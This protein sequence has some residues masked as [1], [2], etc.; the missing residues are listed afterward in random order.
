MFVVA[1]PRWAASVYP[2]ATPKS[3]TKGVKSPK[4]ALELTCSV[5]PGATIGDEDLTPA[6]S[7][8]II[9]AI[10]IDVYGLPYENGISPP[11]CPAKVVQHRH[12]GYNH[13]GDAVL[14][15]NIKA[16]IDGPRKNRVSGIRC[17]RRPSVAPLRR[18]RVPVGRR[19][20]GMPRIAAINRDFHRRDDA[21]SAVTRSPTHLIVKAKQGF[22]VRRGDCRN[23]I[24][25]V[26]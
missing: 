14:V 10:V 22:D 18:S 19:L 4:P 13:A 16:V 1:K 8:I 15:F 7:N 12:V 3:V 17:R 6:K 20:R 21:T 26:G 25:M 9:I 11:L 23:R 24:Y 2:C 5:G